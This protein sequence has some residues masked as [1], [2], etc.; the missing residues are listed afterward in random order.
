MSSS[1]SM[2]TSFLQH[3]L[4]FPHILLSSSSSTF[5]YSLIDFTSVVW[6]L[7]RRAR[8]KR[9]WF[10]RDRRRRL[11]TRGFRLL[12]IV[13]SRIHD[14][15][16]RRAIASRLPTVYQEV[17]SLWL[18][19]TLIAISRACRMATLIFSHMTRVYRCVFTFTHHSSP[20]LSLQ[21]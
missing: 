3:S 4:Y 8:N 19:I 13:N 18:T 12:A 20:F 14:R 2:H 1:R 21:I 16:E 11:R 6:Y 7:V 17:S 10:Q 15:H 5:I 9:K